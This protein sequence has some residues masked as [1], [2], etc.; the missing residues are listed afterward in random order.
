MAKKLLGVM[1]LDMCEKMINKEFKPIIDVLE[2]RGNSIRAEVVQQVKK[3]FGLYELEAKIK[4]VEVQLEEL[5]GEQKSLTAGNDAYYSTT[6]VDFVP[7][8]IV[9]KEVSRMMDKLNHPL[10]EVK[11]T[12]DKTIKGLRL[13]G[14]PDEIQ[15][16]FTAL[17]TVIFKLSADIKKLPTIHL[18]KL[19]KAKK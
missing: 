19:I 16:V 8:S 7:T 15:S 6:G 3:S 9:G 11:A 17:D 14:L 4:A 13:S 18:A 1:Q 5:K 12:Q 10:A 2:A